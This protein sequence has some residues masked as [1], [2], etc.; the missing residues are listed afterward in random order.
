MVRQRINLFYTEEGQVIN[1]DGMIELKDHQC[2]TCSVNGSGKGCGQ[3]LKPQGAKL[4]R[5][6]YSHYLN[7]IL[8]RFLIYY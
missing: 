6:G 2:A 3:M 7:V 8:R 5:A 4:L 1:A